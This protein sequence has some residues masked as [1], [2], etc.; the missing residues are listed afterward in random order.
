MF[1]PKDA[2]FKLKPYEGD[3]SLPLSERRTITEHDKNLIIATHQNNLPAVRKHLAL[4]GRPDYLLRVGLQCDKYPNKT[5]ESH[6]ATALQMAIHRCADP[7]L[8]DALAQSALQRDASGLSLRAAIIAARELN[9]V[10]RSDEYDAIG[11]AVYAW[12]KQD[13]ER[14]AQAVFET[15]KRIPITQAPFEAIAGQPHLEG[16][17]SRYAREVCDR[18]TP[19]ASLSYALGDCAARGRRDAAQAILRAGG[20]LLDLEPAKVEAAIARDKAFEAE[21]AR[22]LHAYAIA[23][24]Q[25]D[26]INE[27]LAETDRAW[28]NQSAPFRQAWGPLAAAL[29]HESANPEAKGLAKKLIDAGASPSSMAESPA[30]KA[31]VSLLAARA[32]AGD[33][34]GVKFL[35]LAG[36][37]IASVN[38]IAE[39]REGRATPFGSVCAAGDLAMANLLLSAGAQ[40]RAI[41]ASQLRLI[42]S[43]RP[44]IRALL[45]KEGSLSLF[46]RGVKDLASRAFAPAHKRGDPLPIELAASASPAGACLDVANALA[47]MEKAALPPALL[48]K[49]R[50]AA[51]KAQELSPLGELPANEADAIS[52]KRLWERNIPLFLERLLAIPRKDRE[53]PSED[54]GPSPARLFEA[55][56]DTALD[57]MALTRSRALSSARGRLDVEAAV[58]ADSVGRSLESFKTMIERAEASAADPSPSA[59]PQGETHGF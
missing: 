46:A 58:I 8:I 9:P 37:P 13:P 4:G 45:G 39:A 29:E 23:A 34:E 50:L 12:G 24:G 33:Q 56:L 1:K 3:A 53:L 20:A 14:H 17:I 35:L 55:M 59:A 26:W 2:L 27:R 28:L 51:E 41:P 57:S 43:L 19:I 11:M 36:A 22:P 54:G 18:E 6:T 5:F 52:L 48:A 31:P 21:L 30:F 38:L 49:G 15:L 10:I 25:L 16:A 44:E 40:P 32:L 42:A 47:M 7:E